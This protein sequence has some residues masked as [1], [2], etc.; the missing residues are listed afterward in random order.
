MQVGKTQNGPG[1]A[2]RSS[3]AAD[4]RQVMATL[5]RTRLLLPQSETAILMSMT[6]VKPENPSPFSVGWID[7]QEK[8]WPVYALTDDLAF[9]THFEDGNM[10][11][12]TICAL[13]NAHGA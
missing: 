11:K 2:P 4:K 1:A 7:F 8:R 9:D 5:D 3:G 13:L 12:R 10:D 6:D